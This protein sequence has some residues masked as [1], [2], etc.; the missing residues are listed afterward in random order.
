V[1]CLHVVGALATLLATQTFANAAIYAWHDAEGTTHYVDN[2]DNVPTEYRKS[3]TP[4]VKDWERAA[5]PA[6]DVA[7]AREAQVVPSAETIR[8]IS[9][10]SFE[11]GLWAGRQSA[12]AA[13][14]QPVA[15]SVGPIVQ[16]VQIVTPP[17]LISTFPVFGPVFRRRLHPRRLFV[18]R[19]R[20]RFIQGPAGPPPL[21]AA[22][23]PPFGAAGPPPVVFFQ[24]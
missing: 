16:N 3:A 23:P 11:Q 17:Q 6:E 15:A 1:R 4:L 9:I 22:G 2:L 14:P 20:G 18:P 10:S 12:I 13:R 24:H 8:Q 7:P 19:M 5:P 21:G